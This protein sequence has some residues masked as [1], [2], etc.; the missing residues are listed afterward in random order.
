MK[1]YS[2]NLAVKGIKFALKDIQGDEEKEERFREK[3]MRIFVD[4][5]LVKNNKVFVERGDD[6][7]RIL[8]GVLRHC[9]PVGNRDNGTVVVAFLESWFVSQI[10]SKLN[11]G[12]KL[13]DGVRI[14]QHM[15]PIID[16]LRNEALKARRDMIAADS[17]R[18][19]IVKK[20]LRKPWIRLV[21]CLSRIG[22]I[23]L[24]FL[25]GLPTLNNLLLHW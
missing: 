12:K 14:S 5:G 22:E 25:T 11:S 2:D 15:P 20:L 21:Q 1:S 6:K 17:N 19:I 13:K 23:L 18:K 16:A 9:H 4:Q 3:I 8:S 10:N 7:G 24:P